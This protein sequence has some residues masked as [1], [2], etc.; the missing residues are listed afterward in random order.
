MVIIY[1]LNSTIR[2]IGNLLWHNWQSGRLQLK[3]QRF[4]SHRWQQFSSLFL[5]P[6]GLKKKNKEQMVIIAHCTF[7][8]NIEN[9]SPKNVFKKK[10]LSVFFFFRAFLRLTEI[11]KKVLIRKLEKDARYKNMTFERI[12][13]IKNDSKHISCQKL[14]NFFL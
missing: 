9:F 13:E 11:S 7:D 1:S 14:F 10:V 12:G 6:T 3:N 5:L 2:A 4:K 8:A